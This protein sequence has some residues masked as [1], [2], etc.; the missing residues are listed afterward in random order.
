[1][2]LL[3]LVAA[4]IA[5]AEVWE[6]NE[7]PIIRTVQPGGSLVIDL[8][9]LGYGDEGGAPSTFT[10]TVSPVSERLPGF[11]DNK[12]TWIAH[13]AGVLTASN[14]VAGTYSFTM[15]ARKTSGPV[16]SGRVGV[17]V[18]VNSPPVAVN[19]AYTQTHA[20]TV[21][22]NV[23]ANDSDPNGDTLTLATEDSAYSSIVGNQLRFAAPAASGTYVVTY[24][25]S[26][27]KGGTATAT[28]TFTVPNVAP[29]TTSDSYTQAH[30][31]TVDR[32][33]VAND[34]DANGDALTLATEDSVY[35]SIVANQ[36]RFA[37]PAAS[38]TYVVTYTVSDG[39]GGTGSATAT[40]TVPN[41]SPVA[42]NDAYTQT[43]ATTVD[44]NVIANDSDPNGDTLTLATED[45]AYSTIVGNQLRFAAPSVSGTYVVTYTVS[46]G[47]GGTGSATATFTVPNAAPVAVNDAYT[48]THATTVDRNVLGNDSDPNGDTLTLATEDS[49][50]S[51]IVG[52]Q[53]RFAAPAASG[54]YVVTYTVS[55]G[56][57]GTGAATATFTVPNAAPVAVNDAYTQGHTTTVDHNVLANDTDPNGDA[58]TL[59]SENSPYA[60]ILGN[61]LRFAA[62][63]SG[64]PFA[65]T[66]TISD[67]KGGTATATATIT[68]PNAPPVAANDAATVAS[69]VAQAIAVTSNDADSNGTIV[70]V[71]VASQPAHGTAVANPDKTITYTS[72]AGYAGADSFT[73]RAIDNDGGQ[74]APATVSLTVEPAPPA[75]VTY[76]YDALGRLST[77]TYA[78]G[79]SG[80][81]KN[82]QG[83]CYDPNGNRV[84]T[85]SG[86]GVASD[87]CN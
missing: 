28:A 45:S 39:K 62:P 50:Y 81:T 20:T 70:S 58:L 42:V 83:Y 7:A 51:S 60:A 57:G 86:P 47:K 67:G 65:V 13:S 5:Q 77:A 11:T 25:V 33:V 15:K 29:N 49:A 53:L 69:G 14:A 10:F 75:Q 61:Q 56:K 46:D 68:V 44:R 43:H 79:P 17:R 38:G 23:L 2:F 74:S 73:Y 41:V 72:A 82:W 31:T 30:S 34:T 21:D 1:M 16:L 26:D 87:P 6:W 3:V 8:R 36:L 85:E 18:V 4:P 37:A 48:Q 40:F 84:A 22:H 52:N 78:T 27:G 80:A 35:A 32:N 63:A 59:A 55:D 24:T 76:V 54:T 66:Y 12:P 64:G 71:S 19:D 9:S